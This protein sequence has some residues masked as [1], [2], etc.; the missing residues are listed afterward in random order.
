[1]QHA[2]DQGSFLPR[3]VLSG[4]VALAKSLC[5]SALYFHISWAEKVIAK[6]SGS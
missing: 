1:M 3:P 6:V 5:P 2:L 4:H